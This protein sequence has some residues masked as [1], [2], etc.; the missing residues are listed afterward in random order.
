MLA[1]KRATTSRPSYSKGIGGIELTTSSV[2]RATS[3]SRSADSHAR[4]NLATTASSEGESEAGGGS[5]SAAGGRRRC[6]L[7][8]PFE[9]AV[10]RFDGRVQHVGHLV[11]VESEDVAQDEDS[12]LAR[13]QDL[14][15]GHEGQRDGFGLLVAGLRAERHVDRALE[16][17]V[18]KWLEPHDLA[19]PGRLG[20]FNLGHVPLLGRA[21]AGRPTRVEAPVGGDPVEPGAERGAAFEPSEA[22]PGGQQ[23][24]LEGVLGVLEG[25]EHPVAVQ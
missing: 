13:R 15:G 22:L 23:R 20:R 11:R 8:R 12:E 7:A 21:S 6:R 16:E 18:G 1:Q 10:D 2:R 4:T 14:Q 24:V 19:E 3:A 9:G 17:G 25:S 5:R